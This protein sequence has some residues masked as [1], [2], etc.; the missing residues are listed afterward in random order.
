MSLLKKWFSWQDLKNRWEIMDFELLKL[1]KM[2]LQPYTRGEKRIFCPASH[3]RYFVI[4]KRHREAE[5]I[6]R[7][8]NELD[9]L[10]KRVE[11]AKRKT[12]HVPRIPRSVEDHL[13]DQKIFLS[14]D[15]NNGYFITPAVIEKLQTFRNKLTEKR[16]KLYKK[17]ENIVDDDPNLDASQKKLQW[18]YFVSPSGYKEIKK[19]ISECK[20]ESAIF[21]R[22]NVLKIEKKLG[23]GFTIKSEEKES[24]PQL[25]DFEPDIKDKNNV[26]I[27]KADIWHV[28]YKGKWINLRDNERIR[29]IVYLLDNPDEKIHSI[30]L[31]SAVKQ[32]PSSQR[33]SKGDVNHEV[34]ADKRWCPHELAQEGF[35]DSFLDIDIS[36]DDVEHLKSIAS[37]V[38]SSLEDAEKH[39]NEKEKGTARNNWE[40]CR[41]FFLNT[42][43]LKVVLDENYKMYCKK[44]YEAP[45]EAEKARQNAKRQISLAIKD[46][47]EKLPS[48]GRYL[49]VHIKRGLY[50]TYQPDLVES[51]DWH[52]RW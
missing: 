4:S 19:V 41:Y 47:A 6:L 52:I 31:V 2:G 48:L 45:P 11:K 36:E 37:G 46:I 12:F 32:R 20:L 5:N 30:R 33:K 43:K 24:L 3:H 34:E 23:L 26:F 51:I 14:K 49:D 18:K 22:N 13:L 50:N 16:T 44:L 1:F 35:N 39:G 9:E 27:R 8:L 40:K 17:M 38:V 42:Y 10:E 21:E 29:Y 7:E 25:E 28:K 15:D